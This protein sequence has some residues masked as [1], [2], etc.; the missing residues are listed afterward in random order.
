MM[1]YAIY[2]FTYDP[3]R[4]WLTDVT[5]NGVAVAHYDYD[6]NG[7]R[8][9]VLALDREVAY[10]AADD[11][12]RILSATE[13][14]PM[15]VPQ[16]VTWTYSANG[17]LQTKTVGTTVTTYSYD[18]QG[19]LRHV[20]LSN[21]TQIDYVVD[22]YSRRIGKKINGILIQGWVYQD[23][24]RPIAELDSNN[25]VVSRFVYAGNA[26]LPAYIIKGTALY[27]VICDNIGSVRL[28]INAADGTIV[29]RLDYD[30]FGRVINDTNPGFQ[31]FGFA[32][33]LYDRDTKLVRFGARDYDCDSGR[34]TC[35][36][37]IGFDGGVENVYEY[38][39]NDPINVVDAN[40]L[41]VWIIKTK[42]GIISHRFVIG[43]NADGTYW[44]SDLIPDVSG[45]SFWDELRRV[46]HK[47]EINF[48]PYGPDPN[49]PQYTVVKHLVTNPSVDEQ[50]KAEAKRRSQDPDPPNYL[51]YWN[52]CR[53]YSSSV[54]NYAVGKQWRWNVD[55]GGPVGM[56]SPSF[57]SLLP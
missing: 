18:V 3:A 37:P 33:G 8:T 49:D 2:A 22:A 28:V 52:D 42:G 39:A 5:S 56:P 30:E 46:Y 51:V 9:H 19:N 14:L 36:D 13:T 7:N 16:N 44:A 12:D 29:Q 40:G 50:V 34:W 11:Q 53:D 26:T 54:Y 23:G 41:D 15:Q 47:G 35:K 10:A 43:S 6:D 24:L 20:I 21:G 17:E 48:L 27:R 45:N 25:Q 1:A 38:A 32:G 55:N 57:P 4:G 31:P